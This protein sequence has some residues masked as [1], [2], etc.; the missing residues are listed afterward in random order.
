MPSTLDI[1]EAIRAYLIT[2][3]DLEDVLVSEDIPEGYD[4]NAIFIE[5]SGENVSDELSET[6]DIDSINVDM[7]VISGDINQCRLLTREVKYWLRK[8]TLHS[9]GFI[10]DFG[11][12]RTIHGF[13]VEDHDDNYIPKGLENFDKY[14]IGALSVLVLYGGKCMTVGP[15]PNDPD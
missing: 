13:E 9:Q 4:G 2:D 14:H 11:S 12:Q 8:Y 10:D 1:M 5:R 6:Y 7:E 15:G 3:T